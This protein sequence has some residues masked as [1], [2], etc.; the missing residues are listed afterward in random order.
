MAAAIVIAPCCDGPIA[1][2]VP[3]AGPLVCGLLV[4]RKRLAPARVAPAS[5]WRSI[6]T[7]SGARRR[8]YKGLHAPP[9][10]RRRKDHRVS[11]RGASRHD[12]RAE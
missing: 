6:G 9:P 8:R 2:A 10:R 5:A 11:S 7:T 3:H 12:V 1:G 4:S